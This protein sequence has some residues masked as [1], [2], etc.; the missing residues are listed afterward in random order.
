MKISVDRLKRAK[1]EGFEQIREVIY[2]LSDWLCRDVF[3]VAG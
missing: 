1:E 2:D 3:L